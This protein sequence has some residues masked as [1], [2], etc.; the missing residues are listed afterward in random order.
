ME[1]SISYES[2]IKILASSLSIRNPVLDYESEYMRIYKE[3]RDKIAAREYIIINRNNKVEISKIFQSIE[4][5]HNVI[6]SCIA[7]YMCGN[8]TKANVYFNNQW[9]KANIITYNEL[10]RSHL[11]YRMRSK[12]EGEQNFEAPDLL[13]IPLNKRDLIKNQR[14][15]INGFP[16]L[17]LSTSL[18]QCWEELRRPN[19]RN[20]YATGIMFTEDL[21]LFD[22]RLI[23]K[24]KTT[25]Q[26]EAFLQRLPL[27][28]AC[29]IKVKDDKGIFIPEYIISQSVLHTII[30]KTNGIDGILYSSMRK[31]YDYYNADGNIMDYD[32]NENIVIPAKLVVE[33]NGEKKD[34]RD[35]LLRMIEIGE[36]R[37]FEQ[38]LIKGE[39]G[40]VTSK[41]YKKTIFGQMESLIKE[42]KTFCPLNNS[43]LK[44]SWGKGFS[45]RLS[46]HNKINLL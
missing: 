10:Y 19:L 2:I 43:N 35:N 30:D 26:L 5:M 14:F 22:L 8:I 3:I 23:R 31:D 7:K 18:Y 34:L 1:N 12:K 25:K 46:S 15:S 24:I 11:F 40:Y 41:S 33:N 45:E 38:E 29:S 21:K 9:K 44:Y 32:R 17:Y 28:L 20:L 37:N 13:H 27:I 36:P 42:G 16:C 4:K 6:Q 39:I